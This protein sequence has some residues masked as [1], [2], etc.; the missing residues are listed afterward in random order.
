VSVLA[1]HVNKAETERV[2]AMPPATW[3]AYEH[4]LRAADTLVS[5]H[6]SLNKK[7]LLQGRRGL[8]RV[9][10]IDPNYARA[11]AA[12]SRTYV[13]LWAYRWD[14]DC[15]WSEA[16]DRA[17]QSACEAVRLAPNLPAAHVALGFTLIWMR[18]HEAAVAEFERATVLN[19]NL[20]DFV[21]GWTL[22]VAGEPARAI[23]L[24]EAHMRLDP[25]YLPFAPW[26]LGAACYMLGHYED[27]ARHLQAAVSRA[28]NM[29][30][31]HHWLAA[32]YSQLGRLDKARAEL[33]E[34]LRIQPW[35]TINQMPF[36]RCCKRP[37]DAEHLKDG[38][39]KAGYPE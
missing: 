26:W 29:A 34:G 18:R 10:A 23:Q 30:L 32:T 7:D 36:I 28:P 4:Y 38:L 37:S 13:S 19:P 25:F 8:S 12:L 16:L 14:E 22:V 35:F 33:V 31:G 27:A 5:F 9:L 17:H 21:F 24:L 2:L 20:N 39:L 15:P 6:S 11:H 1:V 3:Q